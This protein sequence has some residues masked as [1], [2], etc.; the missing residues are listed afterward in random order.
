M[1]LAEFFQGVIFA[2]IVITHEI[3]AI[4]VL[5]GPVRSKDSCLFAFYAIANVFA[6]HISALLVEASVAT[7]SDVII[8]NWFQ[9]V[10]VATVIAPWI[11]H[12]SFDAV[13]VQVDWVQDVAQAFN[14]AWVPSYFALAVVRSDAVAIVAWSVAH[15]LVA[16]APH[17]ARFALA[18]VWVGWVA[19]EAGRQTNRNIAVF[20]G[21]AIE[22]VASFWRD[23]DA[24]VAPGANTDVAEE[25]L[26]A[27]LT[28]AHIRFHAVPILALGVADCLSARD[29]GPA[30]SA[31]AALS[32]ELVVFNENFQEVLVACF[33]R[34]L[35]YA[36]SAVE[37]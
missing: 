7:F 16:D 23:A 24:K 26:P 6:R 34:I 8:I 27:W 11:V 29:A 33:I 19:V 28:N 30:F 2:L 15:W 25:P 21:V 5:L 9:K 10:T 3:S 36:S 35:Q 20:A 32:I 22:A 4:L 37:D 17:P 31:L 13:W 1:F 14:A 18:V 12:I